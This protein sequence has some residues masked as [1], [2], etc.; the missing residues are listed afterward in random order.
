MTTIRLSEFNGAVPRRDPEMLGQFS[1]QDAVNCNLLD[2]KLGPWADRLNVT[3]VAAGVKA[4]L[5]HQGHWIAFQKDVST[6]PSPIFGDQVG[7]LYWSG[8]GVPKMTDLSMALIGNTNLITPTSGTTLPLTATFLAK[9]AIATLGLAIGDTVNASAQLQATGGDLLNGKVY[10][11]FMDAGNNVLQTVNGSLVQGGAEY[12]LSILTGAVIPASTTQIIV[13]GGCTSGTGA[14]GRYAYLTKGAYTISDYP[15]ASITL[16]VPAP[17][18]KPKL[19]PLAIA[20]T[21]TGATTQAATISDTASASID[22]GGTEVT[23]NGTFHFKTTAQA[24][25]TGNITV[26]LLMDSAVADSQNFPITLTGSS[27]E[28]SYTGK[29]GKFSLTAGP[30]TGAH[31]YELAISYDVDTGGA[32]VTAHCSGTIA[33]SAGVDLTLKGWAASTAKAY[34]N[35]ITD[36]NGNIQMVYTLAG[37]TTKSGAHPVWGTE[38]GDLT[39]DNDLIWFCLGSWETGDTVVIAGVR[40]MTTINKSTTIVEVNGPVVTIKGS[41]SKTY[42]GGGTITKNL[43]PTSQDSGNAEDRAYVTTYVANVDGLEMEGGPSAPSAIVA[44]LPERTI[45]VSNFPVTPAGYG[46]TKLRLYRTVTASDGTAAFLF[47]KD[48]ATTGGGTPDPFFDFALDKTLSGTLPT[49]AYVPPPVD[50]QGMHATQNGVIVGFH[51]NEVILSEP[52]FP[53]AYPVEY[54]QSTRYQLMATVP[55]GG[56]SIACLT[57]GKPV[58][59]TG[60]HPA[61]MAAEELN[62]ILPCVSTDSAVDMGFGVVYATPAGLASISTASGAQLISRSLWSKQDWAT[63]NPSS[64]IAARYNDQYV[65]FYSGGDAGDGGFIFNPSEPEAALTF[66]DFHA[67][68][69]WNDPATGD[70]YMVVANEIVQWDAGSG[71]LTY[72]WRSAES[73]S[74]RPINLSAAKVRASAYPVTFELYADDV[75]KLTYAVPSPDAF[76]LPAGYLATRHSIQLSGTADVLEAI[77]SESMAE[78]QAGT[79]SMA[80][81]QRVVG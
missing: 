50:M 8:D 40:G 12:T 64:M 13:F 11:E 59:L 4:V 61:D 46:I 9:T 15:V 28:P 75:L 54:R 25:D 39:V 45:A 3:A 53:H 51:S 78:L 71:S 47:V 31:T 5:N 33:Q 36:T 18:S 1:A 58:M 29:T 80:E 2:G 19:V 65:C 52:Y 68:A 43:A 79:S 76:K 35:T 60:R 34:Q 63:L 49:E 21:I 7:R 17:A 57:K 6:V 56:D 66:L 48:I 24:K 22:S 73:V 38:E 67:T 32:S 44:V 77:A 72:T 10:V 30:D 74:P 14:T 41:T 69:M 27:T 42:I 81:A 26:S 23:V 62:T 20:C 16:G 55:C 70:L 37:G